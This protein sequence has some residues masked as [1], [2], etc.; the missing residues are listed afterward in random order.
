MVRSGLCA[1]T[2]TPPR[3]INNEEITG[4]SIASLGMCINY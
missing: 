4:S 3:E 1:V 2:V